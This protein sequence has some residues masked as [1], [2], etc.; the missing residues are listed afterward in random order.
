MANQTVII[1]GANKGLGFECARAIAKTDR[2]WHIVIACRD[3][4]RGLK[5][6]QEITNETDYRA[7]SVLNLDLASLD[8]VNKFV[9]DFYAKGLPPLRGLICN[10]GVYVLDG[11]AYTH[12]GFELTFGVNYLGHFLLTNLLLDSFVE[13]ARIVM[14]SSG[15]HNPKDAAGRFS[16][17][18]F[19]GAK[20]L[21]H[22]QGENEMSGTQRYTTSKLC[23]VLSAYELDRR[24]K[25][26]NRNITI[27]AYDPSFVP[28]TD[29]L[30]GNVP[31]IIHRL[32]RS[33][34]RN[35][36]SRVLKS[37]TSTPRESGAAMARLLLDP[38]LANVSGRYF[39]LEKERNS[40]DESYDVEK[41]KTLWED[42][43]QLV[44]L[45]NL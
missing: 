3:M 31:P 14:V 37:A 28:G 26:E 18:V 25:K 44:G 32:L 23:M 11:L 43:L 21:A 20:R 40:S 4:E 6:A 36:L 1:T 27:N 5:S 38:S 10:A 24:L 8:S 19:V 45:V 41:A 35:V 34:V 33:P 12:D 39:Q 17:P 2:R 42:S 29:L 30:S 13:P 22:P 16:P 7:I 15:T 9:S